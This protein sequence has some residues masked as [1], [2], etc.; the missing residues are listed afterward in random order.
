M[1]KLLIG[2]LASLALPGCGGTNKACDPAVEEC[3]PVSPPTTEFQLPVAQECYIEFAVGGSA[4][5]SWLAACPSLNREGYVDPYAPAPVEFYSRF[6]EFKLHS[7][8][9]I[10][11]SVFGGKSVYLYLLDAN[12]GKIL[13]EGYDSLPTA[14]IEPGDYVLEISSGSTNAFTLDS[15]QVDF[16][17][18]DCYLPLELNQAVSSSWR[19]ECT[20]DV[21]D[22]VDP[23]QESNSTT[24]RARYFN[25]QVGSNG[26]VNI[27]VDSAADYY[28]YLY[29]GSY[30]GI[31][32]EEG[33]G[34]KAVSLAPGDYTL[35]VANFTKDDVGEFNVL[36]EQLDSNLQCEQTALLN[37]T[38]DGGWVSACTKKS[39]YEYQDP[40]AETADSYARYYA[41]ALDNVSDLR[42]TLTDS[43]SYNSTNALVLYSADDLSMPIAQKESSSFSSENSLSLDV[44]LASGAYLVEV[45]SSELAQYRL[46]LEQLENVTGCSQPVNLGVAYQ[47]LSESGCPMVLPISGNNDPYAA[48]AA[49]YVANRFSFSLMEPQAISAAVSG[50]LGYNPRALY[51][52]LPGR[53]PLLIAAEPSDYYFGS[54]ETIRKDLGQGDYFIELWVANNSA[55]DDFTMSVRRA[56]APACEK[57][58]SVS[59]VFNGSLASFCKSEVKPRDYSNYDPY[60]VNETGYFYGQRFT[61]EVP[62]AGNYQ[63]DISASFVPEVYIWPAASQ[64]DVARHSGS[65]VNTFLE[66]GYYTIELTSSAPDMLGS[67]SIEATRSN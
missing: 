48:D 14:A 31:P 36:V 3:S 19:P 63:L 39:G 67:F 2:L 66:A 33:A 50:A 40:Y 52:D 64:S 26:D 59:V 42:L 24:N 23:Y 5:A 29:E 55:P 58:L 32:I 38:Q 13:K 65:V 28:W 15:K 60:A 27:Q 43:A 34:D 6:A 35:E 45:L 49:Q 4:N 22:Y 47:G 54:P 10:G 18:P 51:R 11:F 21:R 61:F 7:T 1:K 25:F 30:A 44:R 41:L 57:F 62:E 20:S 9:D 12:S 46:R 53:S 56:T 37:S 16:G 8:Q 17:S